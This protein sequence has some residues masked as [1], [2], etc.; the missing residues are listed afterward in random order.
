MMGWRGGTRATARHSL[1]LQRSMISTRRR[2][3]VFDTIDTIDTVDN[4]D[5][6]PHPVF[7][8]S[9]IPIPTP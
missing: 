6:V 4:I 8:H 3:S 7:H 9:S 2:S 5:S 1:A